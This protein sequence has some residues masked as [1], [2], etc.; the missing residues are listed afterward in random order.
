MAPLSAEVTPAKRGGR[1]GGGRRRRRER[2]RYG[3]LPWGAASVFGSGVGLDNYG[4]LST[5]GQNAVGFGAS[6]QSNTA[7]V[8]GSALTPTQ[9]GN[10]NVAIRFTRLR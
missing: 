3:Y 4:N 1:E 2:G 7:Q 10:D 9:Q 6:N 5:T 8:N